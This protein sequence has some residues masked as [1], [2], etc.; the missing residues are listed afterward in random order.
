MKSA[1][2]ICFWHGKNQGAG[3]ER[4]LEIVLGGDAALLG[5]KVPGGHTLGMGGCEQGAK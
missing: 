2:C 5:G 3:L 1:T 4:A